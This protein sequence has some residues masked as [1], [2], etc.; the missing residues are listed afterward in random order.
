MG[1]FSGRSATPVRWRSTRSP[2]NRNES[3]LQIA[4]GMATTALP[5]RCS[6]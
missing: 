6:Q 4:T 1:R 3:P 5:N 2:P